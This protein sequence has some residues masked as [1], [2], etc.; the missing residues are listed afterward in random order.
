MAFKDA[1]VCLPNVNTWHKDGRMALM[2]KKD[3]C[4]NIIFFNYTFFNF[5]KCKRA[6]HSC[7]PHN[8]QVNCAPDILAREGIS[9]NPITSWEKSV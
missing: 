9:L 1:E 5:E 6:F 4:I 7:D 3:V 8:S 2:E